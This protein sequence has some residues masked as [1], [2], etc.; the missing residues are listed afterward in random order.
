MSG[1][2]TSSPTGPLQEAMAHHQ[3]G[4]VAAAVGL[5]RRHLEQRPEDVAA[6]C[7]LASAEG[8][9]GHH[10]GAG[11]AYR[12]AVEI[13]PR[14][15]PA[16]AGLGTSCLQRGDFEAAARHLRRAVELD[17][18]QVDARLQLAMVLRRQARLP[19]AQVQ[20]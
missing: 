13:A 6:W 19:V 1:P 14:H 20:R 4:D 12:R 5:Y 8:Q 7:L 15:A 11:E 9:A 17:P 18:E 10:P 16:H 3:A 2:D